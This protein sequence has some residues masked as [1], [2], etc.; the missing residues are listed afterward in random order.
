MTRHF[1]RDD[2][3]SPAEQAEVLALAATLKQAPY[4]S[5][6]LAGPRTVGDDL[7][8]ADAAH[9]GVVRRRHRRARRLPDDR[10]RLASPAS[11]SA[12]R[13]PTS[14]ACSG[15]QASVIVWRT[16]AQAR[17]RGDGRARRRAGRQRADRRVPPLPAARRPAH[18]PRAQG[19]ARRAHRRVRR[20]RRLQH[21][22]LLAARRRDRRAARAGRGARGPP[23]RGAVRRPRPR[24]RRRD[25][26]LG[27]GDGRP[28][29][30]VTGADVVVT[31]TWVSMGKEEEAAERGSR[32]S[33]P[34][35][36]P[37]TCW[38][39][40]SPTR[41]SCTACRRTA[42]RRSTPTSST[43]RRAWS[44]TRPRTACTPRRR[45]SPGCCD[46]TERGCTVTGT[47]ASHHQERPAPADRR[48]AGRP[49]GALAARARRPAGRARGA[50]HPGDPVAR[51]GGARRRPGAA[52][53]PARSCTPYP[54]RAATAARPLPARRAAS[55]HR[56]GRL[57]AELLVS[58]DASANLVVLRTPPG[59]RAVPRLGARQGRVRRRPRH[60]RRRRHRPGDRPRPA[61]GDD[62]ARRLLAL[63]QQPAP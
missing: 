58:A 46:G 17:A 20:R 33:A 37:P 29:E 57:L 56:L 22:Q 21:G 12:S 6:S 49:R 31:D 7:R 47:A 34:T 43:A 55:G 54:P 11:A 19:R 24:D 62:L 38:R 44:G 60:H 52:R 1:L 14:R 5:R 50:G 8:Q 23:A 16:Y 36:S 3:L 51:P 42:A 15:R 45:S 28:V 30:A 53:R 40:P 9:A 59:R 10:R 2:D 35:P 13:S 32:R 63:A 41:S 39:S 27:R 48:P 25:R 61:G 18:D 26:R 4:D